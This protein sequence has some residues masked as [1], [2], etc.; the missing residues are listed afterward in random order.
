[1]ATQ[2]RQSRH[3]RYSSFGVLA[4]VAFTAIGLITT[5]ITL[6]AGQ[7]ELRNARD[8]LRT[9]QES[10]IT[11]RYIRATEQLGSDKR[12]V[13]ISALY[14][15]ERISKDSPRDV[16]T[17]EEVLAAYVREHDP[18]PAEKPPPEP[19]TDVLAALTILARRPERRTGGTAETTY[20]QLD[21][22]GIRVPGSQFV[23]FAQLSEVNLAGADLSKSNLSGVSFIADNSV[24]DMIESRFADLAGATLSSANLSEADLSG[25]E[26]YEANLSNANLTGAAL[27]NSNLTAADLRHARL[28]GTDLTGADMVGADVRGADLS[29][30]IGKTADE[31][32]KI[33]TWDASTKF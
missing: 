9:A 1:L 26:M 7:D 17:I 13:R 25:A 33:T 11:D 27:D 20:G 5:V 21:L 29:G 19:D 4:G 24:D 6:N 10:Q 2:E 32:K 12:D 16:T 14:A 3:Q 18:T 8:A 23:V 31:I 22:H 28:T 30:V 15:L